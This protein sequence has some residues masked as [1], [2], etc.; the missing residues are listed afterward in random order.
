MS[1]LTTEKLYEKI[2]IDLSSDDR[3][4]TI[5][6]DENMS[7]IVKDIISSRYVIENYPDEYSD[8]YKNIVNHILGILS[9]DCYNA[10]KNMCKF[11]R[12]PYITEYIT[13][14]IVKMCIQADVYINN[15]YLYE[16]KKYITIDTNKILSS[17]IDEIIYIKENVPN[18]IYLEHLIYLHIVDD[19]TMYLYDDTYPVTMIEISSL[20]SYSTQH[21]E[22]FSLV[23]LLLTVNYKYYDYYIFTAEYTKYK[24]AILKNIDWILYINEIH[25]KDENILDGIDIDVIK[26]NIDIFGIDAFPNIKKYMF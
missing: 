12:N 22:M 2:L 8:Y 17:V 1:N 15:D 18:H 24:Y 26:N 5:L 11:N 23:Y 25:D 10:Y 9:Y 3:L 13:K 21:I 7:V 6:T 14:I 16:L 4:N 19:F 20:E